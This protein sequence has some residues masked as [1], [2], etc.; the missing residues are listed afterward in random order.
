MKFLACMPYTE[1]QKERL[2]TVAAGH[3]IVFKALEE[4]TA[5]DVQDVE[6]ILGNVPVN[7]VKQAPKL[8][9]LQTNSAGADQYCKEGVLPSDCMLTN[10]SGAYGTSVSEWMVSASFM[11]LRKLDLYM[12]NQVTHA[13]K[14]E[15]DV[16]SVKNAVVLVLGLGDIGGHYAEKM[17]ALGSHVIAVTKH[18]HMEK[19]AYADEMHT[20]EELDTLLPKADIVAMVLPGTEENRNLMNMAR[21]KLMKKTAYLINAGRGNSV[22]NMELNEA[23][24]AGILAGAALD[25]TDP[26]PLPADH[27]LWDAPRCIITPH[28]SGKFHLAETFLHIVDFCAENMEKFIAGDTEHMIHQVRRELG[29]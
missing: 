6:A 29:Y 24:H 28:I 3:E 27:P 2:R 4:V 19:P 16:L 13:W 22:D 11:L 17:H 21:F 15:G 14:D 1:E 26:E 25:V 18:S 23:L 5:E 12:R 8:R 10:A 20:I 7:L 9:W